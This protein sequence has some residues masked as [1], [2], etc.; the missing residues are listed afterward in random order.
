MCDL[1]HNH[2]HYLC[3]FG[4]SGVLEP[5][6]TGLPELIAKFSGILQ[7]SAKTIGSLKLAIVRIFIPW[8]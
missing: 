7:D 6:Y 5:A 8:K 1:N 3:I 2:Y 4:L